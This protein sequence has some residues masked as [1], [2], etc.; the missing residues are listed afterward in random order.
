MNGRAVLLRRPEIAFLA[1]VPRKTT[2][3]LRPC[4]RGHDKSNRPQK[5]NLLRAVKGTKLFLF[6]LAGG[7]SSLGGLRL[8]H[9]LLELIDTT[10]RI[11]EFLRASVEGM[12]DV[13]DAQNRGVL[14]GT[15][16][17]HVAASATDFRVYIF[18]MNISFHK[19]RA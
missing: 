3:P 13:A 8:G 16:L 14:C 6:L 10:S 4:A 1:K 12:A 19:S 17:D 9:A 18:R 5:I 7:G 11:D 2:P 15:G